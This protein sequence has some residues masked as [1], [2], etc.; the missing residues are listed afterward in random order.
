RGCAATRPRGCCERGPDLHCRL[1]LPGGGASSAAMRIRPLTHGREYRQLLG[2]RFLDLHHEV[3]ILAAGSQL[4]GFGL[5]SFPLAEIE[6]G[7]PLGGLVEDAPKE[8]AALGL[9]RL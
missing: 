6:E 7:D 9:G 8:L 1:V 5:S 2:N 4:L 3:R